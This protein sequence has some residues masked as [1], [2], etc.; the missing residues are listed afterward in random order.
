MKPRER[1][2]K[3]IKR[4]EPDK[5][6]QLV[7]WG[8]EVGERLSDIYGIAGEELGIRVGNDAVV[9]QVG[10]NA[11]MEMSIGDLKDG[12]TVTSEWGVVYQRQSGFNNPIAYP[13]KSREDLNNF[14]FPDPHADFRMN[15]VKEVMSK[16][17]EDYAVIVDLSSTLFEPAMAHL[18]GMENFLLDCYDDPAWV[19]SLLDG[20]ADYYIQLGLRAVKEG[21]DIIRIGDDIGTQTA[22]LIPPDLWRDLVQ[23][24]LDR[25]IQAFKKINPDII[26]LYHS[27]G[28]FRPIIGDL[29][30]LGVEFLSTM[31]PVGSMDLSEIKKEFG[32]SVAFKGGLDTQQLLPHGT[33]AEV[34]AGVK[35]LIN[36]LAVGGGYVFMPAHLLYQD[37]PI[38]NIWAML[39]AVKDYGGYPLKN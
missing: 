14:V 12:E 38:E 7:R 21:V 24:R 35:D 27:C 29:I 31:Q 11:Y 3:A 8:K 13:L 36:T 30:Q 22:M 20:L 23:P 32:A 26:I 2:L 34:R 1:F 15:Q 25:M 4:Q 18:R 16:Y 37:V 28:D 33:P 9:C 10:I 17:H 6:P 39:E 5:V 19:G